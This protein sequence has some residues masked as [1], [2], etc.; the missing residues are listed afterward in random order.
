MLAEA[1]TNGRTRPS[2]LSGLSA[3]VTVARMITARVASMIVISGRLS[4]ILGEDAWADLK[5]PRR[6]NAIFP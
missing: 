4:A 6:N 2:Y 3:T 5:L 1:P